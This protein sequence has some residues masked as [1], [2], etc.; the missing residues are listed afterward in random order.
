MNLVWST[1][2]GSHKSDFPG[3]IAISKDDQRLVMVA[4]GNVGVATYQYGTF[5]PTP[6]DQ[7]DENTYYQD[8]PISSLGDIQTPTGTLFD[9]SSLSLPLTHQD[10]TVRRIHLNVWPNPTIDQLNFNSEQLIDRVQIIDVAGKIVYETK[11]DRNF[12][13]INLN[14]LSNGLYFFTAAFKNES[15]T[16][17]IVKL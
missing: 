8:S 10:A 1:Y 12:G 11:L 13:S 6:Y 5:D 15:V 2:H 17:K 7:N 4:N 9:I 14:L 16:T 3:G